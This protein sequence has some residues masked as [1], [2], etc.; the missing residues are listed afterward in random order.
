MRGCI[1]WSCYL[2]DQLWLVVILLKSN[3]TLWTMRSI[4]YW[5]YCVDYV[6]V[7]AIVFIHTENSERA[8]KVKCFELWHLDMC[9]I[10]IILHHAFLNFFYP[11]VP[12]KARANALKWL[13][14]LYRKCPLLL[15][16]SASVLSHIVLLLLWV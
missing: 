12:N 10:F 5:Q 16:F 14:I 13:V 7:S 2:L 15:Y 8:W 9:L 4:R 11:C 3:K 6:A 1:R